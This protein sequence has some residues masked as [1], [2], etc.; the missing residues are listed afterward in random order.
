MSEFLSNPQDKK[1]ETGDEPNDTGN[2]I[3]R[4]LAINAPK[5]NVADELTKDFIDWF[6]TMSMDNFDEDTL[7]AFLDEM[8][9]QTPLDISFDSQASLDRFHDRFSTFFPSHNESQPKPK[10]Q[11]GFPRHLR[12]LIAVAATV[13]AMMTSMIAVQA[14]G[15]D[16]FGFFANWTNDVFYFSGPQK[17]AEA[18]QTR[19]GSEGELLEFESLEDALSIFNV[20]APIVPTWFPEGSD[21]FIVTGNISMQGME[22]F[23]TSTNTSTALVL[24]FSE[25]SKKTGP[26]FII[27]KNLENT[28]EY[29]KF[30]QTHYIMVDNELCKAVW[31]VDN[32]QCIISGFISWD[33]I[34]KIIDSIYEV[35]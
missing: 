27:E 26:K 1:M 2:Q 30:G 20:D 31:L 9:K 4:H 5:E 11:G 13:V 29:E 8:D 24:T 17:S 7:N 25:F 19:A 33:E 18:P 6:S 35:F 16:I 3:Q 32:V 34:T 23:A 28:W 15:F 12:R 21:D 14:L 22:V 10:T